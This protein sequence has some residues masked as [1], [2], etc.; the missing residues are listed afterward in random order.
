MVS[1]ISKLERSA[2]NSFTYEKEH[3]KS[4]MLVKT[5]SKP[6]ITKEQRFD[7]TAHRD[8]SLSSVENGIDK[9]YM[10]NNLLHSQ[11]NP[12]QNSADLKQPIHDEILKSS[13]EHEG[14]VDEGSSSYQY[15]NMLADS[16]VQEVLDYSPSV[17]I[18]RSTTNV[19]SINSQTNT[20][21]IAQGLHDG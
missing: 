16:V 4:G 2:V 7:P 13:D 10:N 9:N 1:V 18:C 8:P 21:E 3:K 5:G 6:N 14:R 11:S 12:T 19:M 20:E 15:A 17:M